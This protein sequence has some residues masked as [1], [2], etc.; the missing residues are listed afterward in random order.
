MAI[1]LARDV[2][3]VVIGDDMVFLDVNA[4]SYLCLVAIAGRISLKDDGRLEGAPEA[5]ETLVEAGLASSQA[6]AT[7][8]VARERPAKDLP[9]EG[10]GPERREIV[11]AVGASLSTAIAFRRQSFAQLLATARRGRPTGPP[12]RK[13]AV[14]EAVGAFARLR[15]WL[16]IGGACFKR[17][18]LLLTYLHRLG[19][20]AD[21]VIGVRTWPFH[22]HCWLQAGEVAL[23][24]DVER[25][26]AYT[27]ILRV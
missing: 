4:D 21:W 25:L 18:Y 24:D 8:A 5:I 19:L 10:R 12:P 23:D 6:S 1:G 27:P 11:A 2:H 17:S 16:P 7:P 13:T 22:A 3:A 9:W 14:L 20:D 15:P 26:V